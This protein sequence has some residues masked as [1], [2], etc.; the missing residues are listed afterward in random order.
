MKKIAVLI[1][2]VL[3]LA[4]LCGCRNGE[5]PEPEFSRKDMSA[6]LQLSGGWVM[7]YERQEIYDGNGALTDAY[8][9]LDGVNLKRRDLSEFNVQIVNSDT[10]E[11]A[12]SVQPSVHFFKMNKAYED[13]ILPVEGVLEARPTTDDLTAEELE[14]IDFS[15]LVFTPEDVVAVYNAAMAGGVKEFGK[16]MNISSANI[17]SDSMLDGYQWQVGYLVLSGQIAALDIE[18]IYDN[19]SYLSDIDENEMSEPPKE[20]GQTIGAITQNILSSGE[21]LNMGVDQQK[22]I[23]QVNFSRLYKLLNSI[24]VE[25]GNRPD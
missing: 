4:G 20:L 13:K 2:S 22:V 1:L 18:L 10:G 24:E 25:N 23:D 8:C 16:Y 9:A 11:V 19:G 7:Y 12:G 5:D 21:L 3:L 6:V 15:G 14:G 17:V